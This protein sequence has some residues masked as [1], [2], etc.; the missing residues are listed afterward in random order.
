VPLYEGQIPFDGLR[1]RTE[2]AGLML[3]SARVRTA[4]AITRVGSAP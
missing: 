1:S 2:A 3:Y 4:V